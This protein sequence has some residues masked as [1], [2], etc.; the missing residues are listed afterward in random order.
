M[1]LR[2]RECL[3]VGSTVVVTLAAVTVVGIQAHRPSAA[4]T[5]ALQG[6]VT[7]I[8]N[9][10][11]DSA[12]GIW[13]GAEDATFVITAFMD[14]TCPFCQQLAPVFDSLLLS[15][16]HSVAIAFQHFPL[17]RPLSV[18]SAI[19]VECA[20]F[21]GRFREMAHLLYDRISSTEV[22]PPW[23]DWADEA[24]VPDLDAFSTCIAQPEQDFPRIRAGREFGQ[25]LG[26]R[27]TPQVW[28]NG[29]LTQVRSLSGFEALLR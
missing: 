3:E 2:L 14:L 28:V 23:E 10:R 20:E 11:E 8:E 7:I 22:A 4:E 1:H 26:V 15:H 5:S 24:E 29:E 9:W 21:Q 25:R 19:A 17:N 18:P 16:P 13:V 12:S 27:G 6:T